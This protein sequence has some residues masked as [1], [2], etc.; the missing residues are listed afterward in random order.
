ML[1]HKI[2][3]VGQNL[4]FVH[5]CLC[6]VTRLIYPTLFSFFIWLL[7]SNTYGIISAIF[8]AKQIINYNDLYEILTIFLFFGTVELK[9][10]LFLEEFTLR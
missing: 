5:S 4:I 1:A 7:Y 2:L 10:Q 6:C 3:V 8:G 9:L